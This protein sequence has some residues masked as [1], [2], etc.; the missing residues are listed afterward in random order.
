MDSVKI[1]RLIHTLRKEKG[2]T[3]LQLAQAL[4]I[5][6]KTV[7]K[8]ERGLGCPDLSLLPGLSSFFHVD[9]EKLLS[10]ELE[11]HDALG[12][13]M[14]NMKFY[15]CPNCG[16]LVTAMTDTAVSCCGKKL[17]ALQAQKTKDEEKLTVE[18]IENDYFITAE[19]EMTKEHYITFI[20]LVTGDSVTLR[21]L[22]PEWNLQTRLPMI[23]HGMLFWYC[24]KDGLFYQTV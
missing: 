12:G 6:D 17:E 21:K 19:H 20:A 22:Y 8:W 3:Q 2:L 16:N 7:S 18:K 13:T 4:H 1:G 11:L 10:G 14:K 9:L 5:S 15:V 24:T 23:K